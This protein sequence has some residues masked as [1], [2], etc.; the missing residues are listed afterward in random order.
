MSGS[1][2]IDSYEEWTR[3]M[4]CLSAYARARSMLRAAIAVTWTP[5]TSRAGARSASLAIRA[6]PKTPMRIGF[7]SGIV[8]L[9]PRDC[10]GDCE[11]PAGPGY[12]LLGVQR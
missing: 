2:S 10:E 5:F 1:A 12:G 6:A 9:L 3:G 7:V 11:V 8:A 4:S